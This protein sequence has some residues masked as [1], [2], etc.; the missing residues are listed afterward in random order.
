MA[1]AADPRARTAV[2]D[3]PMLPEEEAAFLRRQDSYQQVVSAV[4]R[5]VPGHEDE[6]GGVWI[7]QDRHT[8]V[9]AWTAHIAD[10]RLGILAQLGAA[11]PLEVRLV[12]YPERALRDLQDRIAA[13]WDW[14]RT[15]DARATGV[16]AD[17]EANVTDLEISSANPLAPALILAHY[18]VPADMLRVTS[19]GTGILLLAK[20][21]VRGTVVRADGTPPDP[22]ASLNVE[23]AS[24]HPGAGSGDCGGGDVGYGVGANGRFELPCAPGGWTITITDMDHDFAP[25][26]HGHVVVRPGEAV[27]LTITLDR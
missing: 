1:V 20:G 12:R 23:W 22:R 24:D 6:F 21:T 14:M 5:Y 15:I 25:L 26:G 10:H 13:D 8:V 9:A 19:D 17:I 16:G 2:L 7:D 3:F 4:Q 18:G 27:R 11:G